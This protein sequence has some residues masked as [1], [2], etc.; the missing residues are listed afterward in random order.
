VVVYHYL[1]GALWDRR[2]PAAAELA[3]LADLWVAL[4]AH[5]FENLWI[6]RGQAR[7]S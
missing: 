1:E 5:P 6:G 3:A 7:K 4:H 2:V